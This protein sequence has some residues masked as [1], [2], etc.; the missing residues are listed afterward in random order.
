MLKITALQIP[1]VLP[2]P[3]AIRSFSDNQHSYE[4]E[5][6]EFQYAIHRYLGGVSNEHLVFRY[7]AIIRNMYALVTTDRNVIPIQSFL[8][9]WYW[10]RKEHQ[11]RLEF[12]LRKMELPVQPPPGTLNNDRKGAPAC[13]SSPNAGNILFRYGKVQ[14]MQAMV[15]HG[16][17]RIGSASFYR[18]LESD[19]ARADEER[20]K[21]SFIP[22]EYARITTLDGREIPVL[23]DVQQTV[24]V[25]NYYL[26]C[27]SCDWDL[28]LFNDF[29]AD[30]CVVI[31]DSEQFAE[32]LELASKVQLDGWYFHHNPV[33]YFDPYEMSGNQYFNAAMCKDFRFAYQREYRFLWMPMGG[34]EAEGFKFLELDPLEDLAELH[35]RV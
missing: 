30:A 3:D 1:D 20:M 28:T 13:P 24:A 17:I 4:P 12:F 23:G 8:S 21:I 14:Y 35:I 22:G 5:F 7:Q 15:K 16:S 9:S 31:H 25:P 27:M 26:L 11:T 6:W 19:A 29:S 32:R 10:Y 2:H 33:E 18:H 34:Q